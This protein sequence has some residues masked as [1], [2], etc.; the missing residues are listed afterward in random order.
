MQNVLGAKKSLGGDHHASPAFFL[1]LQ[2]ICQ[3]QG[4]LNNFWE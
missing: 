4:G 2:K 3:R 1:G